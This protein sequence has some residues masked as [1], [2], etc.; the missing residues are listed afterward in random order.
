MDWLWIDIRLVG[1]VSD[2]ESIGT[3]LPSDCHLIGTGLA[4]FWQRIE[5][6]LSSDGIYGLVEP[7]WRTS[8]SSSVE[9]LRW[10]PIVY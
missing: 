5:D 6:G 3:G 2:R 7:S 8:E 10:V 4:T 1:L 9:T